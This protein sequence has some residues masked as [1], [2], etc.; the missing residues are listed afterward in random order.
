MGKTPSTIQ[1]TIGNIT[2]PGE[3]IR[4]RKTPVKPNHIFIAPIQKININNP[5]I[6]HIAMPITLP[7]ALISHIPFLRIKAPLSIPLELESRR[8]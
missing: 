2:N 4:A 1:N 7:I 8:L 6:I 5:D 3:N